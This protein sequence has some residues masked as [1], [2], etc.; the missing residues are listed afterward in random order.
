MYHCDSGIHPLIKAAKDLL[1][2]KKIQ[3]NISR[4]AAGSWT[5]C[6]D[7]SGIKTSSDPCYTLWQG[8]GSKKEA[9]HLYLISKTV[10]VV[11]LYLTKAI[12]ETCVLSKQS[13]ADGITSS[14]TKIL[15]THYAED[16]NSL[17]ELNAHVKHIG[18]LSKMGE[19]VSKAKG[20]QA[21]CQQHSDGGLVFIFHF[22]LECF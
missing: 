10:L 17:T 11:C 9:A 20:H 15:Q 21:T 18:H 3:L 19:F 8:P 22:V 14:K 7:T 13:Q 12:R 2:P 16:A 6:W 1:R 4:L 5:T